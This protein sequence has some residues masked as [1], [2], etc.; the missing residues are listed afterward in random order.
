MCPLASLRTP[1]LRHHVAQGSAW[2]AQSE[3]G[4]ST[5][6]LSYAAFE[7]RLAIERLGILYWAQLLDRPLEEQEIRVHLR[8]PKRQSIS[9]L[10][11]KR[12]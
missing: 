12:K 8:R 2:L 7:F 10:V 9:S 6:A 4:T 3:E 5:V 1:D 11:I